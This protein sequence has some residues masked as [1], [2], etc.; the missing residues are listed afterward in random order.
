MRSPSSWSSAFLGVFGSWKRTVLVDTCVEGGHRG[1]RCLVPG[2][3][4]CGDNHCLVL[5]VA[6][7]VI[8]AISQMVVAIAVMVTSLRVLAMECVAMALVIVMVIFRVGVVSSIVVVASVTVLV[9]AMLG[10]TALFILAPTL[11]Q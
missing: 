1:N 2:C 8:I 10:P 7:A 11:G 5:Q 9:V 3:A 4:D 6:A